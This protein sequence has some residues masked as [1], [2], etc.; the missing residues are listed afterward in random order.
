M[1]SKTYKLMTKNDKEIA[2]V[3]FTADHVKIFPNGNI[4]IKDDAGKRE[5]FISL[6]NGASFKEL[7]A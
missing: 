2:V 4:E 5:L 6:E 7:K 3:T 1:I